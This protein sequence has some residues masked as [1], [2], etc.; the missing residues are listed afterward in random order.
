MRDGFGPLLAAE[1]PRPELVM[2]LGGGRLGARGLFERLAGLAHAPA[3]GRELRLDDER[4]GARRIE[5][6]RQRREIVGLRRLAA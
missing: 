5:R 1:E 3:A 6:Q 4:F 2:R